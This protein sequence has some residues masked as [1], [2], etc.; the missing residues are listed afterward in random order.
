MFY[1]SFVSLLSDV[2]REG[3]Q[4]ISHTPFLTPPLHPPNTQV[5]NREMGN[6]L[7]AYVTRPHEYAARVHDPHVYHA[8]S[9]DLLHRWLY[10]NVPENNNIHSGGD[11]TTYRSVGL[12]LLA[13]ALVECLSV[14]RGRWVGGWIAHTATHT[15]IHTH[16]PSDPPPPP[17]E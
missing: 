17:D 9:L 6:R 8:V 7:F 13:L 11:H 16:N 3:E 15:Y 12:A 14:D 1:R 10:P 4:V 2:E 5:Q